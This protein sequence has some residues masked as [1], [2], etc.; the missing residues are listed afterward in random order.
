MHVC[1]ARCVAC[2]LSDDGESGVAVVE[3]LPSVVIQSP[4][5]EEWYSNPKSDSD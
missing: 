4:E 3:C 1:M 5:Q 2:R